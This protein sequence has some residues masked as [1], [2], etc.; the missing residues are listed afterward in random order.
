[1]VEASTPVACGDSYSPWRPLLPHNRVYAGLAEAACHISYVTIVS[2]EN[3]DDGDATSCGRYM[4]N[5]AIAA[6]TAC[7]S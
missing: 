3:H 5:H 4:Q 7:T 1:M 2:F 6:V